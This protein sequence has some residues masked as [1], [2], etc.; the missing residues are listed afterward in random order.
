MTVF[1]RNHGI[2]IFWMLNLFAAILLA[3]S[4]GLAEEGEE[5]WSPPPPMP[6][7]FDWIQTTSLEWLKGKIVSMYD[8][9]LEF[10]SKEFDLQTLDWSD[11]KEVRSAGTMQVAF[12]D[13]TIAIGQVFIDQ[14]TVRVLG[15][16]DQQFERS[17][18]LSITAGAPKEKN[19]WSIKASLGANLR[20]GNTEQ[21]E[22]SSQAN[23]VRRTP[24]NRINIDYLANFSETNLEETGDTTIADNQRVSAGWNHYIS[25]RF[26]WS[27]VYGEWYR[28]P[29][30]NIA[31]RWT[32]GM[33]AGYEIIDTPKTT[34]DIN[35]GLAYQ[36][37]SFDSVAE[38]EDDSANTP[39]LVVGTLYDHKLTKWMDFV[40]DYR[41][42]IVNDES[43]TYTHH[44]LTGL[45]FELTTILDFDIT[46][47]WDRIQNPRPDADGIEPKKNDFRLTFFLGFDF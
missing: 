5:A 28:D 18:V 4:P 20:E 30:V 16:E 6:E 24:K 21:V 40:F 9:S 11:I 10:D 41:L 22:M 35:G 13:G 34:W 27:P 7:K 8:A 25:K 36:I 38:D 33:G 39:A 3:A 15:D 46:F 1:H 44:L 19:Y 17:G 14:E 47:I 29:F 31:Q 37:T 43:G 26:Y 32:L 42:F 45:E 23:I 2:K 12:E